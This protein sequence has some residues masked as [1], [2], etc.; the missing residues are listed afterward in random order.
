MNS[1]STGNSLTHVRVEIRPSRQIQFK[2]DRRV[3]VRPRSPDRNHNK[4]RSGQ[5]CS[6]TCPETKCGGESTSQ[7]RHRHRLA[8]CNT[9]PLPGSPSPLRTCGE[10]SRS[11]HTPQVAAT[12]SAP[13]RR[14]RRQSRI[15]KQVDGLLAPNA[16]D[17][18]EGK[19]ATR[20]HVAGN[21]GHEAQWRNRA[22][23]DGNRVSSPAA[24]HHQQA[25]CEWAKSCSSTGSAQG[26]S[27]LCNRDWAG[28]SNR[29][30]MGGYLVQ[31]HRSWQPY[32]SCQWCQQP[33]SA[34][35]G[36]VRRQGRPKAQAADKEE[37]CSARLG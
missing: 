32:P 10:P 28:C 6:P 27:R 4:V 3:C 17:W 23:Q 2:P 21:V 36:R 29:K 9:A 5:L 13:A 12:P 16:A 22:A 34:C 37:S 31:R 20:C 35:K 18:R 8:R 33:P 25:A 11:S 7:V 26:T 14:E 19:N 24:H 30:E 15:S 1:K